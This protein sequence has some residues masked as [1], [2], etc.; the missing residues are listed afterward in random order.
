MQAATSHSAGA[1]RSIGGRQRDVTCSSVT[2][3]SI[4]VPPSVAALWIIGQTVQARWVA[5]V[6]VFT[7]FNLVAAEVGLGAVILGWITRKKSVGATLL[8]LGL[9]SLCLALT[10]GLRLE[11]RGGP[12]PNVNMAAG[13]LGAALLVSVLRSVRGGWAARALSA[14]LFLAWAVTQSRGAFLSMGVVVT[15]ILL[16]NREAI[17]KRLSSWTRS[18][19]I[20]AGLAVLAILTALVPMSVRFFNAGDMDPRAN[21]RWMVWESALR[22]AAQ[23]P[24]VGYGPGT[25]GEVYPYFRNA[26][27]WVP[28]NSFAHSEYLQAAAEC[29]WPALAGILLFLFVAG[30]SLA[31]RLKIDPE[32]AIAFWILILIGVHAAVDFTFHEASVQ[33]VVIACVAYAL[34]T[35]VSGEMDLTLR[36]SR[37]AFA[38]AG[39]LVVLWVLLQMGMFSGRDYFAR[40]YY[41]H[42]LNAQKTGDLDGAEKLLRRS[43]SFRSDFSGSWNSLGAL[44][45]RRAQ[46]T[47]D[48]SEKIRHDRLARGHFEKAI[49]SAGYSLSPR[50]NYVECL[51]E[52]GAL[53]EALA[54][55]RELT[56]WIPFYPPHYVREARLLAQMGHV[57]EAIARLDQAMKVDP[58]YMPTLVLRATLLERVGDRAE[59]LKQYQSLRQTLKTLNIKDEEGIVEGNI[60][61]LGGR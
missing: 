41:F 21:W 33:F 35:R 53:P 36:F 61:R 7:K 22:M 25:F 39:P 27:V 10:A 16:F 29:G 45:M 48:R 58:Y 13:F 3:H 2:S 1:P 14:L 28:Q 6:A 32:A 40:V 12:F 9:L 54:F 46:N 19:W 34:K 49:E 37:R 8:L 43:L 23:A 15:V 11:Q 18:Q 20:L 47:G 44:E 51:G 17:E 60:R 50:E 59:A 57:K 4:Q 30:V 24:L 38:F 52:A 26:A 56:D 55:Q 31:R 42:G 5:P